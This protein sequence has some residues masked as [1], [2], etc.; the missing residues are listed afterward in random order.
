MDLALTAPPSLVVDL[1]RWVAAGARSYRETMDAWRTLCPRLPV[2]E[3]AIDHG[4]VEVSRDAAREELTV[5]A[6]PRGLAFVEGHGPP[7]KPNAH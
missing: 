4:L 5:A 1:V 7:R 2:W 6:T 3:D